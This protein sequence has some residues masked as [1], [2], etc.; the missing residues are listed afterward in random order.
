MLSN[1]SMVYLKADTT[2]KRQI[3]SSV[4]HEKFVLEKQ[5]SNRTG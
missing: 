4:F 2:I 5:L 1:L 3:I